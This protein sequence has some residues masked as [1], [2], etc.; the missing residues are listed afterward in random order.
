MISTKNWLPELES[1]RFLSAIVLAAILMVVSACSFR[2]NE[3]IVFQ[4]TE[5]YAIEAETVLGDL[6]LGLTGVFELV[7]P[8]EFPD[9]PQSVMAWTEEG[10]FQ[11]TSALHSLV[12]GE[13]LDNWTLHKIQFEFDCADIPDGPK[14][15]ELTYFKEEGGSRF[16]SEIWVDPSR[17][18]TS[19]SRIEY[20][21]AIKE[22]KTVNQAS[23]LSATSVL[24]IAERQGGSS[25]R[26][27]ELDNCTIYVSVIDANFGYDGW[28]VLYE[29]DSGKVLMSF[30]IDPITGDLEK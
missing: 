27:H 2:V 9:P 29:G 25:I 12:W 6:L 18:L 30:H 15:S 13:S 22:W 16:V 24:A 11:V 4:K 26:Q 8:T 23:I 7:P 19:A 28:I 10:Y 5:Y 20:E 21:P 1:N 14:F 17:N 3:G